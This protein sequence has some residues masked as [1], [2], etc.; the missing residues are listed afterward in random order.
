MAVTSAEIIEAFPNSPTESK[1]AVYQAP[2]R[3]AS[4]TPADNSG[5]IIGVVIVGNREYYVPSATSARRPGVLESF[6]EPTIRLQ[7]ARGLTPAQLHAFAPLV[8]ARI[9]TDFRRVGDR[10]TY[11]LHIINGD[12]TVLGG[13]V[14]VARGYATQGTITELENGKVVTTSS[15]Y[16][17]I[18]DAPAIPTPRILST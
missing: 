5:S 3:W 6:K 9:G 10:W 1:P 11:K 2:D 4:A 12:V 14:T 8:N 15:T 13:T 16:L 17:H 7:G 18:D